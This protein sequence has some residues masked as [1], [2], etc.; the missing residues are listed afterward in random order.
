MKIKKISF[1]YYKNI[2]LDIFSKI[3]DKTGSILLTSGNSLHKYGRFDI[4]V[5]D[6]ISTLIT[7]KKI[8]K[9]YKNKKIKISKLNPFDILKKE[10]NSYKIKTEFNKELPFQGGALGIFSYDLVINFEN[11]QKKKG[12]KEINFP[13]MF[14]G[15]YLWAIIIDHFKKKATL[16]S[17]ENIRERK[18]WI[19]KQKNK[20][21]E[22]KIIKSWTNNMSKKEYF[23][24]FKKIKNYINK[25]ECYQ[26]NLS[27][28][29]KIKY[30]G[31]EWDAFCKLNK[32]NQAPFS[33]FI[34]LKKNTVLS[35][36]PE[37]F[38][39]LK[40]NIIQS[41]PIKGTISR[42]KNKKKD[43][44]QIKLLKNSKKNQAENLMIVDLIRN[45]IGKIAIPG[46]VLVPEL[47]LVESFPSVHHLV[48]T[49]TAKIK[50]KYK[51]T[52]LLKKCFPGGSIT[53]APKLRAIEIIEEIEPDRRN[54]YCGSIGYISFCENMDTNINI[55]CMI[56]ENKNMYCWGG[57]G[58]VS[59]S[60]FEE[61]Y[62]EILNK[63]NKILPILK[64]YKIY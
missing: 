23:E 24:K 34:R 25:G 10:I 40:K 45:D 18:K 41:R 48:S 60:I 16:I 1:S 46:T 44:N 30:S 13:D 51:P 15:I 43:K 26:I 36:S 54:G 57:G 39:L 14:I 38:I 53:G 59:D 29:F 35:F 27:K 58:I 50:K 31:N 22:I 62:Q 17:Y 7:K 49:I 52:D 37:R 47:F 4:I 20:N 6:P 8:T 33:A 63:L 11:I 42:L 28:K 2:T 12:K 64:K 5:S 21:K 19:E 55:R 32:I 61:E 3:S 9:I 56:T